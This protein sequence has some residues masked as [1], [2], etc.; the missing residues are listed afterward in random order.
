MRLL[1]GIMSDVYGMQHLL[2]QGAL[3]Y[4]LGSRPPRLP[5]RHARPCA[6]RWP[7]ELGCLRF[8]QR[9]LMVVGGSCRN[10]LK[11]L[12]DWVIC[13]KTDKLLPTNLHPRSSL[14]PSRVWQSLI[15][16]CECPQASNRAWHASPHCIADAR[17]HTTK[18][19][20][21]KPIWPATSACPWSRAAICWY[22]T[23][24][25]TSKHWKA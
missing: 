10:A 9:A 23:K 22:A 12:L 5:A 16:L 1:E 3:P 13:W 24:N 17:P 15:A 25:F 18:P 11:H 14:C 19:I 8:G 2:K 7:F 6:C 21:S 4:A 20:S